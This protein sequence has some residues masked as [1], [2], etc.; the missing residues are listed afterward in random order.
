MHMADALISPTVGGTMWATSSAALLYCG[1][2]M[3]N[4]LDEFKI[5]LMGVMGAFIFAAQMI[6]FTIPGTGSSGHIC[7]SILL[8]ALLGPY[9]AVIVIASVLTV[10]ALIF[11]DG[12]LLA[13]GCNIFN[14][15]I[16]PAL[17]AY[18]MIYKPIVGATPSKRRLFFGSIAASLVGLQVGAAS[19]VIETWSSGIS[20]FPLSK[21]MILMLSIH[22]AIALIEGII[23]GSVLSIIGEL[24]PEL[25]RRDTSSEAV[26]PP[27]AVVSRRSVLVILLSVSLLI[28]AFL[29]WFASENPD[30]LEWA[31]GKIPQ[32]TQSA[33]PSGKIHKESAEIQQ[34]SSLLPDYQFKNGD[35]DK[36][37][38]SWGSVNIGT[39][40]SGVIGT[41]ITLLLA[42]ILGFILKQKSKVEKLQKVSN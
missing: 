42:T 6:N 35:E 33:A 13:L 12:G 37:S 29:S 16:I 11:A 23:T 8:A 24:R 19:V 39:T 26:N 9:A 14:M 22:L 36:T 27:P 32:I 30:G 2:K 41:I 25:L 10:Q 17:I 34:K 20:A 21:F 28:G 4:T 40:L 5:P 15:G 31:T 3:E 7:G 1:R 38:S 18:P